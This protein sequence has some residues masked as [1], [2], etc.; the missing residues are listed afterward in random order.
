[1]SRKDCCV[2]TSTVPL[3]ALTPVLTSTPVKGPRL[4]EVEEEDELDLEDS[5]SIV[6]CQG[7]D[8]TYDPSNTIISDLSWVTQISLCVYKFSCY[9]S[10]LISWILFIYRDVATTPIH[11]V[12]KYIVYETCLMEL[13]RMCPMC[14]R[15]CTI[16]SRRLGT[17][18]SVVQQC[19]HCEY[20]RTW[21][22]Q[23]LLNNTPAGNLQLSV[24][25]YVSGASFFKMQRVSEFGH[26]CWI[27]HEVLNNTYKN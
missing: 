22:S 15:P 24:A 8:S 18:I 21:D 13:F 3:T 6:T 16:Q 17:F 2:G 10:W 20:R 1:M 5:S 11:E 14:Q 7:L 19:P 12:K 23:P 27:K 26:N 9:A 25:V 4:K